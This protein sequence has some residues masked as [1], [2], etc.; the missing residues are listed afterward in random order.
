VILAVR[1]LNTR[2][3]A[4]SVLRNDT[5]IR[6]V[7][8]EGEARRTVQPIAIFY[9]PDNFEPIGGSE[10]VSTESVSTWASDNGPKLEEFWESGLLPILGYVN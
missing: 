5:K 7:N 8:V 10:R 4:T 3:H 2:Q 1:I 6:S 9:L